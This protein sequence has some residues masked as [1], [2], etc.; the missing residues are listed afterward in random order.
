[1]PA[2]SINGY[3]FKVETKQSAIS[4]LTPRLW[5]HCIGML[6]DDLD[7]IFLRQINWNLNLSI[8]QV[9][10]AQ[11]PAVEYHRALALRPIILTLESNA[12]CLY[13]SW[14]P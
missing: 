12:F 8:N 14:N 5:R 13:S 2:A 4:R 11:F 6:Q 9:V 3:S 7:S 1:M 10:V